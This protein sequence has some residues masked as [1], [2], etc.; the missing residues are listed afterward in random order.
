M[1]SNSRYK[2]ST[3]GKYE[4]EDA[5]ISDLDPILEGGFKVAYYEPQFALEIRSIGE[6]GQPI[7]VKELY[8]LRVLSLTGNEGIYEIKIELS[9][10]A[11]LFKVYICK[12]DDKAFEKIRKSQHLNFNFQ[13]LIGMLVKQVN[14][15][16]KQMAQ[17]SA[18]L[19]LN[20]I[21]AHRLSFMEN[22]EYK[23]I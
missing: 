17:Y 1:Q 22:I 5:W 21:S 14:L 12:L 11:D 7:S 10:E 3:I 13:S 20:K 16:Q 9:M 18:V 8:T 19:V 23:R 4:A 2:S 15:C 6:D